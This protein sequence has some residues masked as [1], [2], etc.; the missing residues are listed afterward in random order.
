MMLA[1]GEEETWW[2]VVLFIYPFPALWVLCMVFLGSHLRHT[3]IAESGL[4]VV[5]MYAVF[6]FDRPSRDEVWGDVKWFL[7]LWG[8]SFVLAEGSRQV[9]RIK[10]R[11]RP[12][13]SSRESLGRASEEPNE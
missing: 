3:P 4:A 12:Q 8:I 9:G 13:G 1:G 10:S 11:R 2:E 7:I 5:F 6:A